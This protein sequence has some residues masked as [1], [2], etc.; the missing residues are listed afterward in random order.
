[1]KKQLLDYYMHD[2]MTA[3]RFE[4]KGIV[5]AEGARQLERARRTASSVIGD[6]RLI[7]DMTFV[8]AVEEEGSALLLR[9]HT[10]GAQIVANSPA[11]RLLAESITGGPLA[12]PTA[13]T[14]TWLPFRRGFV[15]SSV[16]LLLVLAL[17]LFPWG[18]SAA[19][20][21]PETI[22]AWDAYL[23]TANS[24]L[25]QRVRPGGSFLWTLENSERAAAVRKGEIVVAPAPGHNPA[26]VPGGLIHH[27]MGAMFLPGLKV[28]DVLRVTRDYEHFKDYYRPSVVDSKT[29]ARGE[30]L[31][32]FSMRIMNKAFFLKTALDADYQ[33]TN[34]RLDDHRF[35]STSRTTRVQEIEDYGQ[36][37]ERSIPEGQGG[38]YIWRLFGIARFQQ[39]DGGVYVEFEAIAL[40]RDIPAAAHLFVD[41]LVRRVSRNSLLTSLQQTGQALRGSPALVA[42]TS[43]AAKS[44]AIPSSAGRTPTDDASSLNTS[45]SRNT[46]SGFVGAH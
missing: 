15:N 31:D 29:I 17:F 30:A 3:F 43:A 26:K 28:D 40:S 24:D 20:L 6:R 33:A 38:G 12:E 45:S 8:T 35:Y 27:W 11:S 25:Q 36:P 16:E 2:G 39:R 34:V 13:N 22:T 10:E 18:L 41:P 14:R 7:V 4:L 37:R 46:K 32:Q 1:M 19:N 5:D 42:V 21:K 44:A 23:E 9:W